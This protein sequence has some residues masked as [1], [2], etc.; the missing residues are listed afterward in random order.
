MGRKAK[1]KNGYMVADLR[2]CDRGI[3]GD[4]WLVGY[5]DCSHFP[6]AFWNLE[7]EADYVHNMG[8]Y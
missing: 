1:T 2:R 6:Y 4:E 5:L 3:F 8:N 7:G